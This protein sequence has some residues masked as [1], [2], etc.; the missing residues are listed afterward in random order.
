MKHA[1][2]G[3]K[4]LKSIAWKTTSRF[5]GKQLRTLLAITPFVRNNKFRVIDKT[6]L[7]PLSIFDF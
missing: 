2:F 1:D 3:L 4:Q 7:L 5:N 6:T